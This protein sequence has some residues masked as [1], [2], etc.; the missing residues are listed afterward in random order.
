MSITVYRKSHF[1]AAHRLYRPDWD[2]QKNNDVFGKCNNP[3]F[4]G[5]NYELEVGV[6]GEVDPVTGYLIDIK[7][8][9]TI[10]K[11]EVEDYLDHKN[12][13]LDVPEF[14]DIN[15]TMENIAIFI[16]N[17]LRDKLE[18]DFKISVTLYE[19][20]RNYTVYNGE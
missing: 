19:T 7:K 15:P 20:P 1:N 18:D 9:K 14:K 13:N 6:T 17:K 12:L 11:E 4:H 16:W 8:L 2:G 5:H 3:N 10:M